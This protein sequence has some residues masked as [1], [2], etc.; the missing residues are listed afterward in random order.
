MCE[1]PEDAD[2]NVSQVQSQVSADEQQP[3]SLLQQDLSEGIS[4]DVNEMQSFTDVGTI[5]IEIMTEV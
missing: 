5:K 2:T 4:T 1:L 3:E